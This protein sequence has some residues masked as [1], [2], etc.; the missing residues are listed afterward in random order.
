MNC[1]AENGKEENAFA[2]ASDE[3]M[4]SVLILRGV[5]SH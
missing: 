4:C 1:A 3:D 5:I 2:S